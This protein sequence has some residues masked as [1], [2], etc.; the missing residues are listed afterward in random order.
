MIKSLDIKIKAH[1][2]AR[3]CADDLGQ[4]RRGQA[5]RPVGPVR[6]GA[7]SV[8]SRDMSHKRPTQDLNIPGSMRQT[9]TSKQLL[10]WTQVSQSVPRVQTIIML[11]LHQ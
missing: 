7:R 6:A 2:Y 5:G 10:T 4:D 9:D 1:S 3:T 11:L 8:S